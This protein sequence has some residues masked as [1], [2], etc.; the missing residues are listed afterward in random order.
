MLEVAGGANSTAQDIEKIASSIVKIEDWEQLRD[1]VSPHVARFPN[2]Y[3]LKFLLAIATEELGLADEAQ[4]QFLEL[5]KVNQEFSDPALRIGGGSR[6]PLNFRTQMSYLKGTLPDSAIE[7]MGL[8]TMGQDFAYS[9][10]QSQN[11]RFSP[12]GGAASG[13]TAYLPAD[14][15]TCHQYSLGHLRELALELPEDSRRGLLSELTRAGVSDAG[16]ILSDIDQSIIQ[17]DPVAL[18]E[19]H[20]DNET[21][22]SIAI[23]SLVRGEDDTS[24]KICQKGYEAFKDSYPALGFFAAA[25]LD[26]SKQGNKE[27]LTEAINKLKSHG[28]PSIMVVQY[29]V[30]QTRGGGYGMPS[31]PANDRLAQHREDLNQLIADW[32][33]KMSQDPQ[34]SNWIFGQV[35]TSFRQEKSSK[36]FIQFLDEELVR[37]KKQKT[38]TSRYGINFYSGF[39]GNRSEQTVALPEY[40]PANLR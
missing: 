19:A 7:F 5:L 16:L 36:R 32:D 13:T 24:E 1:F 26:Q 39:Y 21:A 18:L 37:S 31:D 10:R 2:D 23:M 29:I 6:S 28:E 33:P 9:Y 4:R 20:P 8:L 25:R 3:R 12:Y 38:G 35:V 30:S 40:P 11:H 27:K 34:M 14:I 22:L 17:Q 15:K